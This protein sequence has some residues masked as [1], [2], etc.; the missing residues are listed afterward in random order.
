MVIQLGYPSYPFSWIHQQL[1]SSGDE[2]SNCRRTVLT[3]QRPRIRSGLWPRRYGEFTQQT[4]WS[5]TLTL[6]SLV[7]HRLLSAKYDLF[8]GFCRVS[9]VSHMKNTTLDLAETMKNHPVFI[10]FWDTQ[11]LDPFFWPI[12]FGWPFL[13]T[14]WSPCLWWPVWI[15]AERPNAIRPTA[16]VQQT[17]VP[18]GWC[19]FSWFLVHFGRFEKPNPGWPYQRCWCLDRG[20]HQIGMFFHDDCSWFS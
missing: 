5:D 12:F 4:N 14:K 9:E 3:D 19:P 20:N 6:E 7:I 16:G 17:L 10:H 18:C 15:Q 2:K 8:A 13:L 1:P 11:W